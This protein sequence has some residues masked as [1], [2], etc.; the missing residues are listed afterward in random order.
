MSRIKSEY[1]MPDGITLCYEIFSNGFDI[2]FGENAVYPT[3]HQPEPYIP[4]PDLSYE[5][6]AIQMCKEISTPSTI[7]DTSP[8]NIRL[9]NIESNIDYLMLLNDPDSASET[10]TE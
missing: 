5:E 4:N 8:L 6:N 3:Y 1:T 10:V 7:D 2:F 9:T